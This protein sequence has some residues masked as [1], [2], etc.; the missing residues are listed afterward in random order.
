M[1]RAACGDTVVSRISTAATRSSACR[2]L[3]SR[4]RAEG[5]SQDE[6]TALLDALNDLCV[7]AMAGGDSGAGWA[8]ALHDHVTM[9][10]QFGIDEVCDVFD[11]P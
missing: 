9:T 4:R 10:V 1:S 6:I 2:E 5:F 11:E 8:L 7:L 3:G